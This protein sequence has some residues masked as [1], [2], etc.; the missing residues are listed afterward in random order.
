MEWKVLRTGV[1]KSDLMLTNKHVFKNNNKK[2]ILADKIIVVEELDQIKTLQFL[3]N[4]LQKLH[5]R[6]KL[7]PQKNL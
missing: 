5:F 7:F 1:D 2:T 4:T 6:S 3:N